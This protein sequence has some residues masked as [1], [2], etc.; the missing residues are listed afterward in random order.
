VFDGLAIVV[1]S[2][3]EYFV[4]TLDEAFA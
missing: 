2:H 3:D 4:T 1:P